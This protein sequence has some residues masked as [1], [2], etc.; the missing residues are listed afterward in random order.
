MIGKADCVDIFSIIQLE[1]RTAVK[2]Q[3]NIIL[4][5][6]EKSCPFPTG[7]GNWLYFQSNRI[8]GISSDD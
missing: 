7:E 3:K 8:E 6:D 5:H 4:V 1:I 2:Y